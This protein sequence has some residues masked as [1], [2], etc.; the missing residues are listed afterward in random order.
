MHKFEL[1]VHTVNEKDTG[2]AKTGTFRS[3]AAPYSGA[4]SLVAHMI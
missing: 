2:D 4:S 3:L 1:T